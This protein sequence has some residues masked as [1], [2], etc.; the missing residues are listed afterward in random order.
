MGSAK[1]RGAA[2]TKKM[3]EKTDFRSMLRRFKGGLLAGGCREPDGYEMQRMEPKGRCQL[4]R[5]V[6]R[7]EGPFR[8]L[9][10]PSGTQS[11]F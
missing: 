6:K 4:R 10:R 5:Q 8:G 1:S 7:L 11:C 2:I 3:P 9:E